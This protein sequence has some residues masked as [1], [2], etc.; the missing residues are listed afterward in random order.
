MFHTIVGTQSASKE[1]I[2]ITYRERVIACDA[3][4]GEATCHTL[5]PDTDVLACISHDSGV[6]GSAA[7]GV[8]ADN[9]T[10]W[11]RLQPERIVVTKVFLRGEGQFLD[12]FYGL[13][14]VWTDVHFLHLVAVERYVVIDIFH[15]L[16][17]A[18]ALKGTHLITTHALFVRIPNHCFFVFRLCL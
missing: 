5:A 4:S 11:C 16:V 12:V 7:G 10:S 15:N 17:Q 6:A 1:T 9:L 18:F 3:V 2:A 13:N 14:V 8:D